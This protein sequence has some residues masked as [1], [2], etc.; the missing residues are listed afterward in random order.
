MAKDILSSLQAIDRKLEDLSNSMSYEA[1]I[2]EEELEERKRLK[3]T[4]EK[5]AFE[6]YKAFMK[7]HGI[8]V[9]E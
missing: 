8:P 9:K 4:G 5:E 3:I 7:A 1:R 2:W 6:H